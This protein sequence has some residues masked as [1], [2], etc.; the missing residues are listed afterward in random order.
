MLV[1]DAEMGKPFVSIPINEGTGVF[2]ND[3]VLWHNAS[4]LEAVKKSR[5]GYMDAFILTA[6]K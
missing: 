2:L 4:R 5:Y 3:Q 6:N 1:S